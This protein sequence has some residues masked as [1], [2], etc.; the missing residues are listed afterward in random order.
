MRRRGALASRR[1]VAEPL[2]WGSPG[3]SETGARGGADLPR[4]FPPPPAAPRGAVEALLDRG[5]LEGVQCPVCGHVG[6]VDGFTEN[7][8]ESGYCAECGTWTRLR[9]VAAAALVVAASRGTPASSLRELATSTDFR[10]YNAEAH[11]PLHQALSEAPGYVCSEY[12]GDD[13]APGTLQPGG[14][15]HEDL[16]HLSF[17]DCSFDLVIS[18]DVFEHVPEPYVGHR[19]VLR[20]LR[21]GGHHVFTV[22]FLPAS[23]LDQVRSRPGANGIEHLMTPEFHDDPMRGD[24]AALVFT[25]FGLEMVPNLARIGF[26]VTVYRPWDPTRGLIE[27]GAMVFDACRSPQGVGP[28]SGEPDARAATARPSVPG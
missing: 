15:R 2:V 26:D 24:G 6:A 17:A 5:R 19:E 20:V 16:Q 7:L 18:S 8:R 28:M 1:R 12:F 3:T 25:V 22:P 23:A 10:I 27:P 13:V 21:P 14:T 11:G 9:Q 4:W